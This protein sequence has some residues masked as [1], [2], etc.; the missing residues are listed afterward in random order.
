MARSGFD[1]RMRPGI[2]HQI[3]KQCLASALAVAGSPTRAVLGRAEI[4]YHP[5]DLLDRR[6]KCRYAHSTTKARRLRLY[7]DLIAQK[8]GE[9][10]AAG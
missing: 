2:C 4:I 7:A 10:L 5:G 9:R 3:H 6:P 8:A 1:D